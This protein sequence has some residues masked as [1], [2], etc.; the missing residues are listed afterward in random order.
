MITGT[1]AAVAKRSKAGMIV[2]ADHDR[3]D[4]AREHP[5]GVFGR[6]ARADRELGALR[7]ERRRPQLRQRD[8]EG[9]PRPQARF[10]EE[11]RDRAALEQR[12]L[13]AHRA[14]L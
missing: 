1:L 3:V 6:L 8:L 11:Q 4:V 2:G 14:F 12:A 13:F 10:F 7:E 9:D 5:R